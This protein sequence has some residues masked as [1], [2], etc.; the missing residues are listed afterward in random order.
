MWREIHD[1]LLENPF[2]SNGAALIG[3]GGLLA[4]LR[5]VP[6]TI[7]TL[8]KRNFTIQIE[9]RE[10]DEPFQWFR[11]WL[12]SNILDVR[13]IIVSTGVDVLDNNCKTIASSDTR[14]KRP[15]LIFSPANGI[16]FLW[17]KNRLCFL[18]R[19][20]EDNGEVGK[21]PTDIIRI[22]TV[23][24]N[25]EFFKKL[26]EESRD[27]FLPEDDK[28]EVRIHDG[29]SG[30]NLLGRINPRSEESVILPNLI[31]NKLFEDIDEFLSSR[32]WYHQ[33]DIPYRRGYLLHGEPG[34]GKTSLV[35]TIAS[36]FDLNIYIID[37]NS[38]TLD[39]KD[40]INSLSQILPNS[41]LLLE[42]IDRVRIISDE[43]KENPDRTQ[44]LS[45]SDLLNSL[46]GICSPDSLIIVMTTNNLDK[47]DAALI[48]PG[49]VDHKIHIGNPNFDQ[50]RRLFKRF[51]H[52]D[53]ADIIK[54]LFPIDISELNLSM[55]F[56]QDLFLEH[57]N[58]P[59]AAI[60]AIDNLFL[61]MGITCCR[62][63]AS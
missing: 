37:L 9:I 12:D 41:L 63:R 14:K 13:N 54:S 36:K 56:Y 60:Q 15:R 25:T 51:Y 40:L 5:D 21:R 43:S 59:A 53:D 28:F 31:K 8:L 46:D 39:E 26:L 17:I 18:T 3:F 33:M 38:E 42:D 49:R 35:K 30:W 44:K 47:L 27:L 52:A 1:F 11:Y 23:G 55:A 50:I 58:N 32:S 6:S 61:E 24:R 29:F 20:Q 45:F 57:K 16:H 7:Y 22:T 2:L 19:K 34:N 62:A 48:R 10:R 4:Y